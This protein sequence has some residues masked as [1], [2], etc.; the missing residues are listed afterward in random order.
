MKAAAN[1]WRPL[2]REAGA[3]LDEAFRHVVVEA[4]DRAGM[5][6]FSDRIDTDY[7][8][9][10]EYRRAIDFSLVR[11]AFLRWTPRIGVAVTRWMMSDGIRFNVPPSAIQ[12]M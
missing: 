7:L 2:L 9:L 12:A 5:P 8:S 1:S 10:L 3:F 6:E 4:F 11:A